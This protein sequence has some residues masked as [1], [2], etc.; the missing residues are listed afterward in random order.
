ME[1]IALSRVNRKLEMRT[2]LS[3]KIRENL[4]E[5]IKNDDAHEVVPKLVNQEPAKWID[6]F[7]ELRN[8]IVSRN[9]VKKRKYLKSV[10]S[11]SYNPYYSFLAMPKHGRRFILENF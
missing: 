2:I 9:L 3:N 5:N 8:A 1:D 4:I 6:K 11:R 10:D 7:P